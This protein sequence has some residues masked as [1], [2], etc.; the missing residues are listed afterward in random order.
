MRLKNLE[1]YFEKSLRL[2]DLA[3]NLSYN[4]TMQILDL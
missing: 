1:Q 4:K 3:Q 2:D